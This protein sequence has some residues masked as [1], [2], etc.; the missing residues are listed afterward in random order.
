MKEARKDCFAFDAV[1][2]ECTALEHV[3]CKKENCKFF[4][5]EEQLKREWDIA[6]RQNYIKGV[7]NRMKRIE[8][9]EEEE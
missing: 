7:I 8:T 9:I 5:T 4:K 2:N 3:Y 1:H 6:Q